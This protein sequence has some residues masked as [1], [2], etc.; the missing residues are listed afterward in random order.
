[1][2]VLEMEAPARAEAKGDEVPHLVVAVTP[3]MLGLSSR[4]TFV[5]TVVASPARPT[6]WDSMRLSW[7]EPRT[8]RDLVGG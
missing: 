1:M 5:A 2:S 4:P 3:A 8:A 7:A 6:L